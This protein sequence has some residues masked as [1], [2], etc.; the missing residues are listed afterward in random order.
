MAVDRTVYDFAVALNE[1]RLPERWG[2]RDRLAEAVAAYRSDCD[3]MISAQL[4]YRK[5]RNAQNLS[6]AHS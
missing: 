4:A 6:E 1:A 2:S 3:R 5:H